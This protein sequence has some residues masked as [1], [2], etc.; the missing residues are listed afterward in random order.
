MDTTNLLQRIRSGD[1]S[2]LSEIYKTY[3]EPFF[4]YLHKEFDL[5]IEDV[6]EVFQLSVV[7]F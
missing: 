5:G 2:A 1:E 6:K 4:A 7:L 3:R